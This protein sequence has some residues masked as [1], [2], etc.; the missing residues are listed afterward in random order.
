ML[1]KVFFLN[2]VDVD[3]TLEALA[4]FPIRSIC[5]VCLSILLSS[6][7]FEIKLLVEEESRLLRVPKWQFF[8]NPENQD[9]QNSGAILTPPGHILNVFGV[10]LHK[11]KDYMVRSTFLYSRKAG[12]PKSKIWSV[13]KRVFLE[14]LCHGLNFRGSRPFSQ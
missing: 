3:L 5:K 1:I 7:S 11:S 10:Q 2:I 9:F 14:Y 13:D 4:H 12:W 8:R 6:R